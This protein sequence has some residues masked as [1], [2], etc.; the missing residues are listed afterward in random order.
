MR[1]PACPGTGRKL[2][3]G[4]SAHWNKNSN[5]A[6]AFDTW[7]LNFFPRPQP[8]HYNGGGYATL[9]FI[10]TLATMI[11]GLIAGNIL[12]DGKPPW[13]KARWFITAGALGL[14]AGLL[15]DAL[16]LCPIVKRIWTPSWVLFSG[17][18]CF[19]YLAGFYTIIEI[20]GFKRW[21]FPLLV[22]GGN[23]IAAYCVANI[24]DTIIDRPAI[25]L[26]G[27]WPPTASSPLRA[28]GARSHRALRHLLGLYAL[29]RKKI[30]IRI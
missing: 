16:G 8:F 11:L 2:M 12:R 23:S 21:A 17:G 14:A 15:A 1:R 13:A 29:Y 5:L 7:F 25:I 6:W 3:S 10:P 18:W 24:S 22:I 28:T 26:A 20:L 19:L 4:F 27:L 30:F 9:S